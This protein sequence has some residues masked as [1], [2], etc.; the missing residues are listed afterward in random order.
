MPPRYCVEFHAT[1]GVYED[2][3]QVRIL[4]DADL[5]SPEAAADRVRLNTPALDLQYAMRVT[6]MDD[7]LG[8]LYLAD[9]SEEVGVVIREVEED[10]DGEYYLV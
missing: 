5:D 10:D 3:W 2:E 7:D 4:A 1:P 9:M 6:P 8:G